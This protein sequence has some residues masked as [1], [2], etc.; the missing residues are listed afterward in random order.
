MKI[1]KDFLGYISDTVL[2]GWL[3]LD[4]VVHFILGILI[5]VICF[6][7]TKSAIKSFVICLALAI[8]KELYDSTTLVASWTEALKDIAVTLI[9]PVI[10]LSVAYIKKKIDHE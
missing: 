5:T 10:F 2:F 6:K 8:L 9:Y 1:L 4:I 3:P 7:I